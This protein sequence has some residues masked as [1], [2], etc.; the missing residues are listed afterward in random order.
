MFD[1]EWRASSSVEHVNRRKV[2]EMIREGHY[3]GKWPA[4]TVLTLGLQREGRVL[5]VLT[6]SEV[7]ANI[8][9]RF[10]PETW[11]LSRLFVLEKVPQNAES[12]FIGRAVRYVRRLTPHPR[13]LISFADPEHG[14]SGVIYK[15]SNWKQV[16]HQSKNLFCLSLTPA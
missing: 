13:T 4:Q 9:V 12:F 3:L 1:R 8:A 2:D 14:H 11:E 7:R 16:E 15:A 5:G 6:F 10:G